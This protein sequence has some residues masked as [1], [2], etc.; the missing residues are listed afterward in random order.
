MSWKVAAE[1]D[2]TVA[3]DHWKGA[4]KKGRPI[5]VCDG[6]KVLLLMIHLESPNRRIGIFGL[7]CYIVI[8]VVWILALTT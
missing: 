3:V 8:V 5:W 1:V 2:S 4:L 7:T 6:W